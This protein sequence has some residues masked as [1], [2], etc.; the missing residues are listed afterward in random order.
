VYQSVPTIFR[1][2]LDTL[3]GEEEFPTLRLI[4]LYGE[5]VIPRDVERFKKHFSQHCLLQHRM[6]STEMSVVRLYFLDKDTPIP[7]SIVPVGYAVEDT[8]VLLLD[9][10]GVEV[11]ISQPGEITIKSGYLSPG[12]WRRPE[13]TQAAFQPDP[14]GSEARL[15][16]TGDLGCLLSDGCLLHLGRK[17]ARVK[18]RGHRIEV[19]EI[20]LALL[21]HAAIKEA[22]VSA[23]EEQSGDPRLVA[24]LVLAQQPAPTISELRNFLQVRL[25]EYMIPTAFVLLEALPL[26]PNGKVDRNALPAP[27]QARPALDN[28]VVPPRTPIE[29]RL[30][31]LWAEIL[32]LEL[33]G[34]HDNFFELGGHSLLATQMMVRLQEAVQVELTLRSLFETP[35]VAG[36]ART[37]ELV[38]QEVPDRPPLAL[39]P[40][41]RDQALPLS[42]AQ[43]RLWFLDQFEPNTPLYNIPGPAVRLRGSLN[44]EA[45]RQALNAI[46]ARHETL[47]TTFTIVDGTPMQVI[48]GRR[49]G[50]L[51]VIDLRAWPEAEREAETQCILNREAGRPFNLANDLMLRALLLRLGK[52]EHVLLLIQHHIASDYWSTDV[53]FRELAAYY[54][55]FT[56]GGAVALPVLPIQY[57]DY[58]I[59]QRQ[60]L[61][62]ARLETQLAY[63]KQQLAGAPPGL[64]LP[65]DRPRPSTQTYRGARQALELSPA[66]TE[67][68]KALSH[69]E[70]VT[71][72][73]TLL[74][75]FQTLLHRYT[76]Q[77]DIVV[78]SPIAGRNRPEVEGLIGFFVNTLTLRTDL[79]G[80]PTFRELLGRVREVA[81]GAYAHQE[82]PFEKLV[83]ELQP[84]RS[85]VRSPLFQVMLVFQ[86]FPR[87]LE[88]PGLEL[89]PL[90][91]H[92]GTAK[93]DLSLELRQGSEGISGWFEYSTDLFEAATIA[94]MVAHLRML[95]E[96]IVTNPDQP[97]SALPLLMEAERH[98]LLVAWNNTQADY[99]VD[100][101]LHHL[102]EVQ[103]KRTPEAIAVVYRDKQLTYRELNQQA[104][105]LAHYLKKQGVGPE[106]L[107][108]ICVERSVEMVVG[109]L[110]ILKAGGA[111]VPLDPAYP[112]ERLAF[113]LADAQVHMLLTQE[114]LIAGLPVHG[115]RVICLDANWET[116]AREGLENPV[117]RTTPENSAY[118]IYTSGSTGKPK[119][120]IIP[121]RGI[122]NRLLWM[123]AA[124][125]LTAT[126]GV[127]QKTPFSF[128]VSVWEFFWPLMTGAR[129][130]VA[131][132]AG[133]QESAYLVEL[134]ARQQI[135]TLHFVPS[136]LRVF[137]EEPGVE[138]CHSLKRVICSGEALPYELQER[139]FAR[140]GATLHNLYGPTEA[141][142]DVTF[143][144]CHRQSTRH[145]VP[146]GS[147]IANTHMYVLDP[148]LQ[149][150]PIG[151]PGELYIGGVGLAR[152]YLNHPE[153]TA[154]RF[155]ANPFGN[156]P[157]ARLYKTGDLGRYLPDG[158]IDFRGRFDDQVKIRGYRIELG[159]IATTLSQHPAIREVVVI[160]REDVLGDRR[161]VAYLLPVQKP[162][163]PASALHSFLKTKLPEYMIPAAF[164]T[165]ETLPL[166]PNGKVDR[167]ALPAPH[168]VRP[169]LEAAYFA[170]RTPT[171]EVV[172]GVW[173]DVLRLTRVGI[174]DNFFELGGHSLL[175]IQVISRLHDL[176]N[177]T[178]P[179]RRFFE[180]PTIGGLIGAMFHNPSEQVRIEKRAALLLRL[181][182]LSEDEAETM[183]VEKASPLQ[184]KEAE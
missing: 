98:R 151:V 30:V 9:D 77:D 164:V 169:E 37:L 11:D 12:Y 166:T 7:E 46:V 93:F 129:L 120:V 47:R 48:N 60:W 58:A 179:I 23:R 41:P 101:C 123:Q 136:M 176:F 88:I 181:V 8:E 173:A 150:V 96:G 59:W 165:L 152:G 50:E 14:V 40:V 62:G 35:T 161:L 52:E 32:H 71:L 89:R 53:L 126:D 78:G 99:C 135:T 100:Q 104:N 97:L 131:R 155:I 156:A 167:R 180:E 103:V 118:V 142:V 86:N 92:T 125:Q 109:L 105:Q 130:V 184:E 54:T 159:E 175:A 31:Q 66:L 177:V 28:P 16:R 67:A 154:E 158:N 141:S 76:G 13:L 20:E 56:A 139:F 69:R 34:I 6:A 127:L 95:L 17:D 108:G 1:H 157:G 21:A 119:G 15:Y 83:E 49:Q 114:R 138:A 115:M 63:W 106:V 10:A 113:M 79:S 19:G 172:A 33:V 132:P 65:T 171:E 85:L 81:L 90:D 64:E 183:L 55:S 4:D 153:L 3:T 112:Q 61:Q 182:Q 39:H 36:L 170:P 38:R 22:V 72:F 29:E 162:A 128:D 102:I 116:L 174:Q 94:R 75:A 84:E 133:H 144:A 68:L 145:I 168:E 51:E 111:Y 45:L 80:N 70:G 117:N 140:L 143:W 2:F 122:C 42:F 43:Q 148:H 178:I 163:P 146:I 121:H 82:L 44:V 160:T 134:I 25:P 24:Y 107:V 149:P 110:G 57:A 91:V 124:Y 5:T 87:L 73:M 26:L 74:A 18:V 27:N 137:L 147:P